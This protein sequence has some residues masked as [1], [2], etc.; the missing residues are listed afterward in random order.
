M[1]IKSRVAAFYSDEIMRE[2]YLD[3]YGKESYRSVRNVTH[4]EIFENDIFTAVDTGRVLA[5]ECAVLFD[6][7]CK[8]ALNGGCYA[9]HNLQRRTFRH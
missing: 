7:G 4:V 1:E 8:D 2:K 3:A 6:Y 9:F 5:K